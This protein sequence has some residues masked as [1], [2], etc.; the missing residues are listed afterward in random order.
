M[1]VLSD[2]YVT[3]TVSC[4]A[5]FEL[6]FSFLQYYSHVKLR[7]QFAYHHVEASGRIVTPC[8]RLLQTL[9]TYFLS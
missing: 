1:Y 6:L 2:I 8:M 4:S 7:I 5:E 3:Y 9:S